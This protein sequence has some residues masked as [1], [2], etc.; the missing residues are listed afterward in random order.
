MLCDG[1]THPGES[2]E[3]VVVLKGQQRLGE[4]EKKRNGI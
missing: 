3:V 2:D 1:E 4:L